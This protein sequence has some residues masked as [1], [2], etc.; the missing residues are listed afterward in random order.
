MRRRGVI[1]WV[2]LSVALLLGLAVLGW[3]RQA[4]EPA[5]VE[6]R[7]GLLD[8]VA[9]RRLVET[10]RLLRQDH[11]IDYRVVIDHDLG[12]LDRHA[13]TEF[14]RLELGGESGRGLLLVLD[15]AANEVR[16]EVGHGLEGI[17]VDAFIAYL[18]ARQMTEFFAVGRVADGIL[19]TTE[20]LVAQV[21]G[22]DPLREA[23]GLAGSGGAGARLPARLGEGAR[24][25]GSTPLAGEVEDTPEAVLAAY[26]QAM[27]GRNDNPTLAIY[28]RETQ[29]MLGNWVV[30][31]A[32]MDAMARSLAECPVALRRSEGVRAVLRPPTG[33]G[34]CPPYFFVR[35]QGRW[36]LDLVAMQA[37]I[38]F[39]RNNRWRL[40]TNELGAYAFAFDDLALDANGYPR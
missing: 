14:R 6:D 29:A 9:R 32:Q 27:A 11:A 10:H 13:A 33:R 8:E 21:Q 28:S 19:A 37:A 4:V 26:R 25:Y 38:R 39:G 23:I 12:D 34:A 36:R 18:E 7:V 2:I 3:Q 5:L 1:P 17:F 20:L 35:E 24:R 16:L 30:T 31:P 22:A 40:E 15:V